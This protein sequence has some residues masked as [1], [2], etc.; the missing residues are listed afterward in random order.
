MRRWLLPLLMLLVLVLTTVPT[1]VFADDPVVEPLPEQPASVPSSG[2]GEENG[3]L[4]QTIVQKITHRIVVPFNTV[5]S[6]LDRTLAAAVQSGMS[7]S[8]TATPRIE[9][10]LQTVTAHLFQTDDLREMGNAALP[11]AAGLAV[12]LFLLRLALY[13]WRRLAGEGD[14]VV[15]V[16]QD[17][18]V[19]GV[20][21]Y[22]SAPV[23]AEVLNLATAATAMMFGQ[24]LTDAMTSTA[25]TFLNPMQVVTNGTAKLVTFGFLGNVLLFVSALGAIAGVLAMVWAF[26][27]ANALAFLLA[28]IGPVAGVMGVVPHLRW[29]RSLWLKAAVLLALF[30]I[31]VGALLR[32]MA[33][34]GTVLAS[35]EAGPIDMFIRTIWLWGMVGMLFSMA[36]IAGKFTIGAGAEVAGGMVRVGKAAIDGVGALTIA[37]A[38]GGVGAVAATG[39]AGTSALGGGATLAGVLEKSG[40][41]QVIEEGMTDASSHLAQAGHMKQAA[42]VL[43][44]LGLSRTAGAFSL[45]A[46]QHMLAARRAELATRMEQMLQQQS[47]AAGEQ[48]SPL[49]DNI[50]SQLTDAL[51]D[52]PSRATAEGVA[53]GVRYAGGDP[54]NVGTTMQ[55]ISADLSAVGQNASE[56]LQQHP[57]E[58]GRLVAAY[59]HGAGNLGTPQERLR[60]AVETVTGDTSAFDTLLYRGCTSVSGTEILQN[61]AKALGIEPSVLENFRQALPETFQRLVEAYPAEGSPQE[62]LQA[63]LQQ[64]NDEN[65]WG[66]FGTY[67]TDINGSNEVGDNA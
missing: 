19:A 32:A 26:V 59:Q 1:P 6:A 44:A 11:L 52:A 23:L 50:A 18:V 20:W 38:T 57:V 65:A 51:G 45:A 27:S 40:S 4:F 62:R 37:G 55:Q 39:L 21:A 2:E 36:G 29:L 22:A 66:F 48:P 30:P 3:G 24:A 13:H 47:V 15:A 60:R 5:V 42:G 63:A 31:G 56:V 25:S 58:M 28:A 12:P 10:A 67:I 33:L 35:G 16:V 49:V 43:G 41:G 53:Q 61:D 17:W 54:S 34:S 9:A 8:W 46:N 7:G 14:S 64:L